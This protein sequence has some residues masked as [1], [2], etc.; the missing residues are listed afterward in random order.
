MWLWLLTVSFTF[1]A[2]L[3]NG[4]AF[5]RNNTVAAIE[6]NISPILIIQNT[7]HSVVVSVGINKKANLI[8]SNSEIQVLSIGI[9]AV[10]WPF[11]VDDSFSSWSVGLV[12]E[13]PLCANKT[14]GGEGKILICQS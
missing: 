11:T 5:P 8:W 4:D 3:E 9:L 1:Q 2:S 14:W 13:C 12:F 10:V 6:N 7:I